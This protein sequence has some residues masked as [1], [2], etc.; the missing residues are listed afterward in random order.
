ML[1]NT[2]L[3]GK[4]LS[5]IIPVLLG[6]L[7]L[8]FG[9]GYVSNWVK[10]E[11]ETLLYDTLYEASTNLINAD[12]DFYQA[13]VADENMYAGRAIYDD[14]KMA[15]YY[16]DYTENY[17]QVLE[18]VDAASAVVAADSDL[19]TVYNLAWMGVEGGSSDSFE[20]LEKKF[21]SAVANWYASYDPK[22]GEG[23]FDLQSTYF[24]EARNY[25]NTMED[26][27]DAYA[28][29]E[30][31]TLNAKIRSILVATYVIAAVL[32]VVVIGLM[33]LVI[34]QI[35]D[36]VSGTQSNIQHLADRDLAFEPFRLGTKDEIGQMAD[37]SAD[38]ADTLKRI[39]ETIRDTSNDINDVSIKLNTASHDVEMATEEISTAITEIANSITDQ[40]TET[41]NASEQTRVL[42]DIV[43]SSNAT[44]ESLAS[45]SEAIG[46]ATGEGMIVVERLEKDT[47][48][49]EAAFGKIFE[50]IDQM[51]TSAQKIAETSSLISDI[52]SQ[53]NLLS[54]NA[55]IEAARA[56]DAGRGFAVVADEIRQLASE[57]ADAVLTIDKMLEE[58]NHSVENAAEQRDIVREAVKVQAE[59]VKMT[60]EKY[61]NIV[62]NVDTINNEVGSLKN[63]SS[64]METSCEVVVNAVNSLSESA[65]NCAANSEETSASTSYVHETMGSITEICDDVSALSE[66][67]K[68]I[69]GAFKL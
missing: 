13:L 32:A 34:K 37:A 51:T 46:A 23:S 35:I 43:E 12:R 44:A 45:V 48:A 7:I 69:V 65:T 15:S 63:L 4:F 2:K 29:Y 21:E 53:T 40:A 26:F 20:T 28:T 54:L 41:G 61:K 31:A 27:L 10:D 5:I 59:N 58:L 68:K 55:S 24:S 38:M 49:N 22:S 47:V 17:E 3:K 67:L 14:A 50:A 9:I 39:I 42:G 18:R 36:G 62:G 25:L 52:A 64:Q 11:L 66:K 30:V 60:G 57:S 56:G 1:K 16:E 6:V 19:Y 33:L 8:A